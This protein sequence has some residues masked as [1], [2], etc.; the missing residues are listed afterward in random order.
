MYTYLWSWVYFFVTGTEYWGLLPLLDLNVT[1][2]SL[3]LWHSTRLIIIHLVNFVYWLLCT[4]YWCDV[5]WRGTQWSGHSDEDDDLCIFCLR[6]LHEGRVQ[7]CAV[8]LLVERTLSK[9]YSQLSFLTIQTSCEVLYCVIF[10][11]FVLLSHI[12]HTNTFC[13]PVMVSLLF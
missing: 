9:L 10:G 11:C 4:R 5:N 3:W 1:T 2:L 7:N 13:K 6:V 8:L 12:E